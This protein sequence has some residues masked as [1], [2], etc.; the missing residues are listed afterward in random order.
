MVAPTTN[1]FDVF[2]TVHSRCPKF[3]TLSKAFA[4]A[5]EREVNK[6]IHY[7][8]I[9]IESWEGSNAREWQRLST[10]EQENLIKESTFMPVFATKSDFY[11]EPIE[12]ETN[13][14]GC[15]ILDEWVDEY[16]CPTLYPAPMARSPRMG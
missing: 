13:A 1:R 12:G 11:N 14:P 5:W 7:H 3:N 9:Q 10:D 6:A 8:E 16:G 15:H 4:D 2:S